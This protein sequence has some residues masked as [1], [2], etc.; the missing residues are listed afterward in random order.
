M[1]AYLKSADGFF[2]L[3]K[4]TT[5]GK[6]AD[7]DLVLQSA[8]IDNHHAL[9]EFNEAEGTFVLQDFNSRNGTFV[10]ECHIQNVAVKLIPGDILRFG[11]AGMTYELV[12]ENPSPVS[13]PWV[14][15]P[16]PW[17]SP[18]PH[19]SSSPPDMPFHHGIQP[20]TVQRSWSQGCPRPTMVPPAPHQRPMSASGKMFS[21]VMDP[22]SPVINQVWANAMDMSEQCMMD[23]LSG[24]IPPT[25]IFMDHDLSQQDKDEII[26]LLG[27]EVNRLSDFEMESKYKDA[28]IM[29]LQAEVAD[30]SQRLSETAAVAAARQSNRC[31]PK[32][33]GVDEGDDLRQKEI[34]SMKSQINALQ[35]GYSQVLSQTLA[36]RNTEIESLK[37][38]GENLKRDHA[39]TSGMVT[40]LQKDMS[41]RNE[42]V[43]QLQEEVNRLR[44]EN[45]EKEYQLEALSS[46]CSVMKEELRKE[47]A[48]KDRREAQEKEL[49]L[50]RSQMQDMEKEVRKLREELKKN[51]MGQNIISKTLREKNKVEEKLQEDSRRKLLQLQEMGNRENLIKINLER[52]VGQLENFRN[53]VIKATFGKTKPFRD[54]PITD[55]QLIE[56]II[57]VTEDNLSFQQRKWTLQRETHLHP[58][59]EETM[60][61]VEKLRVLLD[62]CQACMRDSCSSIDLKKEVELLQHLPLS[63][64]V[65]GLQKTV[66]NILRVSLSWL[67]ETEQLLGDLDIEL[68]DSDKGFSL[69][70]I[71]LLEHYKKI[72]SQSQDLQA[73]MNASRETQK[74]LRQEHLAEKEKLAEKLEQEEKLKAKIQQLTE[75][76]AALEES[77]G[78][79]KSRS[80]EALEKAQARVRELENH[81]ASQKEALENSVA[82]EKRKMR[83][84]LEA[85]RRKAQDLENQLT[86]QKEISENN[87]YEK[88]KMRDTLEKEK[89]KIQDLENR[90]TK[91]KEEI[92]LKE[93][94]ENVLNNKLKDA[95]V[96][97]ED[98][99]QMK[100]TESQRAE[101]LALK[102]KETLAELET[103]KTKM[104]LTD[105]RLKLQQQSMKALQDER[106]SQKHGFEEE[107][108]EYKEQIKQ[109]S[110]TIVS[111]EERLCQVTQYYQKIE[112]E[113]TTLKN[114]DT[115]PKEE[116]SQDL[117][118]G[119]PLDSGDK[120]I[121]C[122]HLIDDL[123]M[124]QKEILSQQE[125]IM[126]L[127][128]DLGEAHS[129]MSDL[130][131]ELSE[132][133]KMELERQ[134]A[135]VRQQSGELSMLK[136]KVAQTTGLMEKKD[137]EL[138]VLRE[139]LRAS[140]EKPRP[141]L[142]TEQ[143]PRTLSQKCDISL[144]IEPAHPDS[145]SSFQEEQSFS[146]LGVKCKGSRHEET[147][148]RQRKA[149]SELRTR[150]RELEKANSCNHKD[151]VNESFLE[152]RTLRMEKNVQ[153]ILL[154]AKPD[155]T[156]LARVEIRPPQNSPFN[157]GST[158]VMEKSVKTDAGEALELSEKLYTDMIKTLGSLMNIK[159]MS[160]HT[161]LKHLSPKEREKVNHL[162]QKDLD[163]VFD[164]ITQLKTRLQRKEELLKGYEQELEQLRHSKVSV[165]MYQTQVAKLEDDVHK[166]AEEK[167]LLKEALERTEQQLSQERRFN[168]VFKQ[169][170][171]RGEDPEQRN[172]SYS[173]FKDNE[174]QRRLFVEMVKSKMQNS[175]V[176]AGAKKATLKTGQER[177]TKK[178]AYKSTQSL[179]FVK[180]GGKN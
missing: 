88:L 38:E 48:Q 49:K 40:S 87:T 29:N 18:Q 125:I 30:L 102:L 62:K 106:E 75:E 118:A 91:Q 39:I 116:A 120:E 170:K 4:S 76:K 7:S 55:Q 23:G 113:I 22:K 167:A 6:H 144:Q 121:A 154:D 163:L 80:E 34:E 53:Q 179:S 162:R 28:L 68:S 81:L 130:R 43:Q 148:Q 67:E 171:D 35:K 107:I 124:A 117:T 9:I 79:E 60:H 155:L 52:A 5:I 133:Q 71:Y 93:Q 78:Q 156:T 161:S 11:S 85:E 21:F 112:G 42:Q 63:P 129:R 134:V 119:P 145:F 98:A 95:L 151:H 168:R 175:S 27:R 100:T 177:E 153:K 137:R 65:S 50:C 84:M 54:K 108:S 159:D 92:E 160:S 24:T 111:L 165:Q 69:C 8:D 77:I 101:T 14:R 172:M 152:L 97:V 10:N 82:Q 36:E 37:N 176:Q 19:L 104:I 127:R 114:N 99:Q 89:R 169:Q 157:S 90:L 136:A 86:Q 166:E 70:L 140:Q 61:S 66:V 3:N 32:L 46:R 17:P 12:I 141:H 128:T 59:Q 149:L 20:A 51:Y 96:M 57:Q 131:G 26:L 74:S 146:D 138:K 115:G 44:I 2:V 150:V 143:K 72:M 15:G 109:H 13:C 83:E 158:L 164:K 16:A 45:R 126:K 180:P 94:K 31:D 1:K 58:K 174:K 64:L 56:K 178:E 73:Q 41:A 139:A 173:P 103:T 47:E 105:D 132:K 123:L 25:E 147:I 110:Q 142:S 135:L 122:D 33:Q